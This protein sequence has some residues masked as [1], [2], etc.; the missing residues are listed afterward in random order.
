[1]FLKGSIRNYILKCLKTETR[2]LIYQACVRTEVCVSVRRNS[3]TQSVEFIK[4]H[5]KRTLC[6][7]IIH[8]QVLKMITVNKVTANQ[9]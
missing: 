9:C 6:L 4:L 3:F 2:G 5:V 7:F 8:P 1:M